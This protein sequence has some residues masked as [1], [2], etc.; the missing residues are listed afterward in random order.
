MCQIIEALMVDVEK[1]VRGFH[2]MQGQTLKGIYS[3]LSD[4][5]SG[6]MRQLKPAF[7]E[8][9][10]RV[11]NSLSDSGSLPAKAVTISNS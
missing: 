8:E 5:S 10:K 11:V 3:R 1:K 6:G 9:A 2:R 4:F 7:I